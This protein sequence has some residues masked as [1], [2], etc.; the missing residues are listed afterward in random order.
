MKRM[1][2][3]ILNFWKAIK[4]PLLA[5][6]GGFLLGALLMILVGYDPITGYAALLDGAF[7]G[8]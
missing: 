3:R 4:L 7:G 8:K 5:V 6:S 2:S 1:D